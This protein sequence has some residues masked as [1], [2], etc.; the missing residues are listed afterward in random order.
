M[1]P[2]ALPFLLAALSVLL[3]SWRLA[4]IYAPPPIKVASAPAAVSNDVSAGLP[5]LREDAALFSAALRVGLLREDAQGKIVIAPADLPMQR[6]WAEQY[7]ELLTTQLADEPHWVAM[8]WNLE[9]SRLHRAL[10]FSSSGRYVRE[11]IQAFN[12]QR[13]PFLHIQRE[14]GQLIWR[15]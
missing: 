9:V 12:M 2:I 11:Q 6:R 5:P 13:R 10:H 8:P 1:K 3:L 14:G 7:P 15:D 4:A